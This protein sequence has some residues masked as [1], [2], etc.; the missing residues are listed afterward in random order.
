MRPFPDL[1][2]VREAAATELRTNGPLAVTVEVRAGAANV[3]RAMQ[4]LA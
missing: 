2:A 3:M 4:E 1:A